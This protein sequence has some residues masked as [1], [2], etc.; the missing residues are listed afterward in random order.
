VIGVGGITVKEGL[1]TTV[2]EEASVILGMI[3]AVLVQRECPFW[4]GELSYKDDWLVG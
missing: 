2:L 3:N 1:T 4:A